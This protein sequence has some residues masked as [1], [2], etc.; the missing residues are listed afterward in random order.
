MHRAWTAY[1]QV[2]M[3]AL[4]HF[5]RRIRTVPTRKV[6]IA[7]TANFLWSN[8]LGLPFHAAYPIAMKSNGS[9]TKKIS[10]ASPSMICRYKGP[11]MALKLNR[12]R[13]SGQQ[14]VRTDQHRCRY[15]A[16]TI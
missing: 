7:D 6:A 4:I 9:T 2:L 5:A 3:S 11:C 13:Y 10:K 8:P 14:I 16:F 15:Q 12:V 1:G